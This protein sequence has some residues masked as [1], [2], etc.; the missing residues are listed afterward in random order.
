VNTAEGQGGPASGETVQAVSADGLLSVSVP[1]KHRA[2]RGTASRI[3]LTLRV[4]DGWYLP[5]PDGLRV[6]AWGGSDFAFEATD[7]H[8]NSTVTGEEPAVPAFSGTFE[9]DLSFSV[10]RRAAS[11]Q[12]TISVVVTYRACGDGACRPEAA[13]AL[14]IPVEVS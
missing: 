5:G 13:L 11:G 7:P 9:A 1:S 10:S 6:E 14:S 2:K 4:G 3:P 8:P 12:R